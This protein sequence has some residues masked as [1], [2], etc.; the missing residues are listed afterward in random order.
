LRVT[1]AGHDTVRFAADSRLLSIEIKPPDTAT[2]QDEK[3]K[4]G[5]HVAPKDV[6]C[7]LPLGFRP[8]DVD[9]DRAILLGANERYEEVIQPSLYC[10]GAKERAAIVPGAEVTVK[11]GFTPPATP[12]HGKAKPA[13]PPFVA[14]PTAEV[15][16]VA[17]VKEL[18]APSFTLPDEPPKKD[19][20]P[21]SDAGAR[22]QDDDDDDPGAPRLS[23]TAPPAVDS[24][25]AGEIALPVTLKNEGR[26]RTLAFVR[27]D[28]LAFDVTGP[29]GTF[30]CTTAVRSRGVVRDLVTTFAPKMS[31]T[32]NV[33]LAELCPDHLFDRPGLYTVRPA[34][35]LR[36][37][38]ARM[39]LDA[40][41]GRAVAPTPTLVRVQKGPRP[42]Y[43]TPPDTSPDD[44]ETAKH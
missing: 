28:A 24:S 32:L 41:T 4:R 35:E 44:K 31:V 27:R 11:L 39:G 3:P 25:E 16:A 10:F 42:F 21:P 43:A 33:R 40:W 8:S 5:R 36:E 29:T 13:L 17:S 7:R 6:Q 14:E 19:S 38:G 37:D 2:D 18:V 20:A 15:P 12:K 22:A 23:V 1:N 30:R 9:E 34:A 26:R